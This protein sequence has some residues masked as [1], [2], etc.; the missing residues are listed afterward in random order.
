MTLRPDGALVAPPHAAATAA[1]ATTALMPKGAC[2]ISSPLP[3]AFCPVPS[4]LRRQRFDRHALL[5]K[6]R[7]IQRPR[8]RHGRAFIDDGDRENPDARRSLGNLISFVPGGRSKRVGEHVARHVRLVAV[9]IVPVR[10]RSTR[11][12][13]A[14]RTRDESGRCRSRARCG[15]PTAT[16]SCLSPVATRRR[17]SRHER[18]VQRRRVVRQPAPPLA[19][20]PLPFAHDGRLRATAPMPNVAVDVAADRVR[21]HVHAVEFP[22]GSVSVCPAGTSTF[23]CARSRPT[24]TRTAR[25]RASS[26]CGSSSAGNRVLLAVEVAVGAERVGRDA[27]E[28]E[29]QRDARRFLP[30]AP[31]RLRDRPPRRRSAASAAATASAST[32]AAAPPPAPAANASNAA[33]ASHAGCSSSATARG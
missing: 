21:E 30:S 27:V 25:R 10:R 16:T 7:Q 33:E 17:A 31:G 1:R 14:S 11:S 19:D 15:D 8:R 13:R 20:R 4:V 29:R 6:V 18:L 24:R 9:R 32:A 12:R 22:S 26:F 3:L 23:F 2:C 28:V 5:R